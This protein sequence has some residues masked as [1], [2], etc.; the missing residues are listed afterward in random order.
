MIQICRQYYRGN[1]AELKLIDQ[2]GKEYQHTHAVH[3]YSKE[4][5]VY[6]LINKALRT[7]DIDQLYTFPKTTKPANVIPVLFQIECKI[8]ELGRIVIFAD[9]SSF[10]DYSNEQEVLFDLNACF[11]S[12]SIEPDRNIHLIKM[13]ASLHQSDVEKHI[14]YDF[15]ANVLG[16]C[17]S[18]RNCSLSLLRI[19]IADIVNT[20][21]ADQILGKYGTQVNDDDD[22]EE[23]NDVDGDNCSSSTPSVSKNLVID[24]SYV[25]EQSEDEHE[26]KIEKTFEVTY[27]RIKENIICED[28][29]RSSS[30]IRVIKSKDNRLSSNLSNN[31]GKIF[32]IVNIK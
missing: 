8:K 27:D 7:E 17:I 22:E 21:P 28:L 6:K 30:D 11:Q 3:W 4:S 26:K 25:D 23:N 1:T 32:F 20:S 14:A 9:I 31:S 13:T 18:N 12:K 29:S 15:R 19:S 2:C 5:F 24:E 10:S 16:G